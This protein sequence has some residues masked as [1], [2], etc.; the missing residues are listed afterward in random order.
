MATYL[1]TGVKLL[2]KGANI[3]KKLLG[4]FALLILACTLLLCSCQTVDIEGENKNEQPT[5]TIATEA[6]T[7]APTEKPTEAKKVNYW[8][9]K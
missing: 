9:V 7:E 6:P 1:V 4:I 8:E 2:L 5:Q 3:M